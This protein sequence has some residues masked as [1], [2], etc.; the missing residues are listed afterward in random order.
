VL[1]RNGCGHSIHETA[2]CCDGAGLLLLVM[3][4]RN[5]QSRQATIGEGRQLSE[6]SSSRS[7]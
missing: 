3:R 6:R 4:L 1:I 7:R 5:I 2:L